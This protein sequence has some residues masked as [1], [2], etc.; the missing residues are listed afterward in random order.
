ME[1]V[2]VS[3][4]PVHPTTVMSGNTVFT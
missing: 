2:T 1:S 4:F 3:A